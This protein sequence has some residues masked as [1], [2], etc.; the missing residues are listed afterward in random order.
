MRGTLGVCLLTTLS[1]LALGGC[2]SAAVPSGSPSGLTAP[3]ES[4]P[5]YAGTWVGSHQITSCTG[6]SDFR[7]CSRMPRTGNLRLSLQ[8]SGSSVS[9]I[10]D[11]DAPAW[12]T[13]TTGFLI[14]YTFGVKGAV[15]SS[16]ELH[17]DGFL[18]LGLQRGLET[19][20]PA[21]VSLRDWNST[22]MTGLLQGRIALDVSGFNGFCASAQTIKTSSDLV[23]VRRA[24]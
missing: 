4:G 12:Y 10:L 17:L 8:E 3:S 9:G 11:I 22:R 5:L 18:D 21:S 6:A 16:G 24:K 7:A 13:G 2:T 15:G 19:C 23:D 20:G 1:L 14:P